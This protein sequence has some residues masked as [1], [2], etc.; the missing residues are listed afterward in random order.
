MNLVFLHG[1]PATGKF[2]VGRELAALT[3]YELFHN[4]V[5][6]DAVL[7]NHAFGTPEF[8]AERDAGWR[9][10]LSRAVELRPPGLISTFN[11]ENT[12]PA[13]F[14]EWLFD[15]LAATAGVVL[16][17]VELHAS[18]E[19][20]AD[21]LGS[22]QRRKFHKL[23]DVRLYAQLRADGAFDQ[24]KIPRTDL[25]IDTGAVPAPEAARRIVSHFHLLSA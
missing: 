5:V 20:I 7:Q 2:T 22:A 13:A 25:R 16:L 1:A 12:V 17:S 9:A 10:H 15:D 14:I 18:E 3:G 6:V 23:T 24:P 19:Q 8:I 4:H 11:P 21:R